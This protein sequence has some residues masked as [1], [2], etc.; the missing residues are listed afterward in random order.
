MEWSQL[1]RIAFA[2]MGLLFSI[3]YGSRRLFDHKFAP[4]S[5]RLR[6]G[7]LV[8][9]AV[10]AGWAAAWV[11]P[12]QVMAALPLVPA[13]ILILMGQSGV[14]VFGAGT[15]ILLGQH[16]TVHG[17]KHGD[18]LIVFLMALLL[19]VRIAVYLRD[20]SSCRSPYLYG[21][22]LHFACFIPAL[23]SW[24]YESEG[25]GGLMAAMALSYVVCTLVVMFVQGMQRDRQIQRSLSD[26]AYKD[27]LTELYNKRFF[28]QAL[29]RTVRLAAGRG[30]AMSVLFIDIDR[31]KHINDS[32][33]HMT[34][35][36]VIREVAE[37]IREQLRA[38]DTA[39]RY[40]GDEFVVLLPGCSS[41]QAAQAA[42]RI[43]RSMSQ[44]AFHVRGDYVNIT[45]SGGI[46][47]F[48]EWPQEEL[49]DAA[50]EALYKAKQNGRNR[51]EV[52]ERVG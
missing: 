28:L 3:S 48:P 23:S 25:G 34:G 27:H 33:G 43:R 42:E 29:E 18:T 7:L 8:A 44:K 21:L 39:A 45:I 51:I 30:K 12:N 38:E 11:I 40:G 17:L 46:S 19:F 15:I 37:R 26:E 22:L 50:D 10:L 14:A 1:M 24:P 20:R 36:L 5:P 4:S 32:Y 6:Q 2:A 49:L 13:V 35:D 47:A 9:V 41:L 52:A 31:F 16:I